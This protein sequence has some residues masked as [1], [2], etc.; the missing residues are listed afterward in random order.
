MNSFQM[1]DTQE[2]WDDAVK[3]TSTQ[4][5]VNTGNDDL[6]SF[7]TQLIYNRIKE[8]PECYAEF[9]VYWF[10][11]KA[12]LRDYG[13]YF[14]ETDDEEMRL[15]YTGKTPAHTLVAAERFK[16]YYRQNYFQGTLKIGR[17]HV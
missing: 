17:A 1:F 15:A 12:V 16:D 11:V 7:G 13:Y 6:A 3:S 2:D 10:A 9:G 8:H 4:L 5:Q 14:G